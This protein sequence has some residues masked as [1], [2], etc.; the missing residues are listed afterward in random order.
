MPVDG[1]IDFLGNE[2]KVLESKML[3]SE[4]NESEQKVLEKEYRDLQNYKKI[5]EASS[6]PFAETLNEH[7][8][9]GGFKKART[10]TEAFAIYQDP[11][12]NSSPEENY[13]QAE[14]DLEA[15]TMVSCPWAFF[16][17]TICCLP[18]FS[19]LP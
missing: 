11:V 9:E 6:R 8:N 10:E 18:S 12:R 7:K 5:L 14:K 2:I 15:R 19:V 13:V 17:T 16:K 3:S 1:I 4:A